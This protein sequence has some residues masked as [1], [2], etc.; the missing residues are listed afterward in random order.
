[1]TNSNIRRRRILVNGDEFRTDQALREAVAEAGYRLDAKVR[2]ADALPIDGSGL[3][4]RQYGFAMRSHFDWVISDP[5]TTEAELAVEFDGPSHEAEE[6]RARDAL[7]DAVCDRLGLPLLRIGRVVLRPF[8]ERTILAV[9][10][11]AWSLWKGFGEAQDAGIIPLDEPYDPYMSIHPR[12]EGDQLILDQ[13]FNVGRPATELLWRGLHKRGVVKA[14]REAKRPTGGN[15]EAYAWA[16]LSDGGAVLG[17]AS[18]RQ[19]TYPAFLDF[20]LA[21]DFAMMALG[22]RLQRYLEGDKSVRTSEVALAA[23]VPEVFAKF[24]TRFS[25]R[26]VPGW[27]FG[28]AG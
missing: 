4:S 9:L 17:E 27:S 6:S 2:V 5:E 8:R 21:G 16:Y 25:F 26:D 28:S 15:V 7:K 12:M 11:D 13:P 1:V 18:V 10:V 14:W 20:D 23:L 22:D 19:C 24:E 3:S